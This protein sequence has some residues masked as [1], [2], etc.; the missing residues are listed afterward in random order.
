MAITYN[1][2]LGFI[3]KA[4]NNEA[5]AQAAATNGK[6]VFDSASKKIFVDGQ[7]YGGGIVDATFVNSV[8]TITKSVGDPITINFS[9]IASA[10]AT[11]AV[12]TELSNKMGLTGTEHTLDYSSTNYL[13]GTSGAASLKEADVILD[14]K[15]HEIEEAIGSLDGSAAVAS[16]SNDIVTIK[17]N[18]IQNDGKI[19]NES[20]P[21][22]DITL[23]K[24]A[25]T[26]N[27]E[28]VTIDPVGGSGTGIDGFTSTNVQDAYEE[29]VTAIIE[30]EQVTERAVESIADAAGL[31]SNLEYVAPSGATYINQATDISN[32]LSLLDAAISQTA[33]GG[34]I[35]VTINGTSIKGTNGTASIAVD[36]TY[37]ATSNKIASQSTVTTA[38]N[39]LD[40]TA[41]IASKTGNVVTIKSGITETDGVISNNSNADIVLEEVASTGAAADVSIADAQNKIT[42]TNVEDALTELALAISALQGSFNVIVSTNAATTPNGVT[43]TDGQTTVTGTLSASAD[44]FHKIYLVPN[45]GSG[46]NSHSE[47]ITT[48]TG[49]EGSYVYG[50]EKLG[51]IEVDLTGYVKTIT[52]NGKSYAVT[53]DS[54]NIN[55]GD[56]ITTVT[57]ETAI[58]GGNSTFVAVTATT[59]S[60]DSTT[61]TKGVTLSS[62]VKTVSVD[63]ATSSNDG[64]ATAKD[65]KDYV[66]T[67]SAVTDA[68]P[69]IKVNDSTASTIGTI[70]TTPITAKVAL[71]WDEWESNS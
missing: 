28:D 43:W 49:S 46:Q 17:K 33:S 60:A 62:T 67:Q 7:A 32:A 52:V 1:Q 40:G 19:E 39:A 58:S 29:I 26:G 38:I 56:V 11:M 48:R 59:G 6:I 10:S 4:F 34:V 12:F 14:T 64:L 70:G 36:G 54:T 9:D 16:V 53:T 66:D 71:Y 35:D 69:T 55:V 18:I 8:L 47:Y 21:G 68:A 44:T 30:N 25:V 41:V 31:N 63:T 57:G 45:S 42:A 24:V 51:D 27:A 22:T 5:A 2:Q 50:W 37:N 23:S 15:I 61:G 20:G 65:V 13:G 3:K